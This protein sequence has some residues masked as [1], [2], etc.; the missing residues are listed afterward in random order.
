MARQ[1]WLAGALRKWGLTVVVDK[2]W[3]SRGSTRFNPKGVVAHHTASAPGRNIPS[4]R[5]C[6]EG[7]PGLSG[8]LCQV[9][10]A[11]DGT[12]HVI[13]AGRANHAGRGR[14]KSMLG[15][16]T[17]LGIE[18]EN[19]GVGEPWPD[20]QKEAFARACAAVV[21]HLGRNAA[22]VG[23]HKEFAWPSGR[24][25]DPSF[26]M[27]DF[28]A[29]IQ[30]LLDNEGKLTPMVPATSLESDT[31]DIQTIANEMGADP[32]LQVDG[33]F[34]PVSAA[35]VLSRMHYAKNEILA[36]RGA[37]SSLIGELDAVR[38]VND[39]LAAEIAAL[40][41]QLAAQPDVEPRNE[42]L[43][44]VGQQYMDLQAAA[45]NV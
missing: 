26:D 16:T 8:P 40:K 12:V 14:W 3:E 32:P 28:R 31:R 22:H 1:T 2:G 20:A 45:A 21:D 41:A 23:G 4:L 27:H 5:I 33:D 13:A 35:G 18:A 15:N 44:L 19:N 25:I 34:G 37:N 30:Q 42:R 17:A 7:R 29:R 6:R 38:G 9:L 11:R 10:I 39:T 43:E 36:L 24:K